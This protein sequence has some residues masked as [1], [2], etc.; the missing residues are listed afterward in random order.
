MGQ[1]CRRLAHPRR[2]VVRFSGN[3]VPLIAGGVWDVPPADRLPSARQDRDYKRWAADAAVC[4]PLAA[5]GRQ[6]TTAI[7]CWANV[8]QTP[9]FLSQNGAAVN[10][11]VRDAIL[12]L[13]KLQNAQIFKH[14]SLF[15]SSRIQGFSLLS[16]VCQLYVSCMSA[17]CQLYVSRMSAVCQLYVSCHKMLKKQSGRCINVIQMFCVGG[18]TAPFSTTQYF[19][20]V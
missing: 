14:K 3:V 19:I 12:P 4:L 9:Q 20:G 1:R 10:V 13:Q 16:A 2:S 17:V 18:L 6:N 5:A 11:L 8:D 15:K 7:Q